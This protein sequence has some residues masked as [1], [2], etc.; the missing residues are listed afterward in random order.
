MNSA[1]KMHELAKNFHEVVDEG[2]LN[3]V[4]CLIEDA[5]TRGDFSISISTEK[6]NTA[7][8]NNLI[9]SL[10]ENGFKIERNSLNES[11]NIKW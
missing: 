4:E 6:C 9:N 2:F 11:L 5:A 10:K 3:N 8:F 7:T 1:Q